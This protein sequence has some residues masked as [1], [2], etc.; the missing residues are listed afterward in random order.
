MCRLPRHRTEMQAQA[1]PP[2]GHW[3]DQ[4]VSAGPQLGNCATR[5]R[6]PEAAWPAGWEWSPLLLFAGHHYCQQ[7]R[8]LV[9]S[10][11]TA[12]GHSPPQGRRSY[13][14]VGTGAACGAVG[15]EAFAR[16]IRDCRVAPP[17]LWHAIQ[18]HRTCVLRTPGYPEIHR[19]GGSAPHRFRV[20]H[21]R[22]PA[23][24]SQK[25]WLSMASGRPARA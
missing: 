20:H 6:A 16:S 12:R 3:Q 18:V 4:P 21:D 15:G 17:G 24:A 23:R 9:A 8:S 1:R 10:S 5:H 25:S 2:T 19:H 7:S 11:T 14:G 22:T 13:R